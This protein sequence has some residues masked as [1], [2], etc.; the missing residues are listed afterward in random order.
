M[1][2]DKNKKFEEALPL[3][4]QAIEYLLQSMKSEHITV[5]F[6]TWEYYSHTHTHTHT[7]MHACTY[8]RT[9]T[10]THMHACTHA[11]TYTC[12]LTD[13]AHSEESIEFFRT[14]HTRYS[15][16]VE[17]LRMELKKSTIAPSVE[18]GIVQGF[19]SPLSSLCM[20]KY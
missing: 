18:K 14:K 12:T 7:R 6:N 11:H 1:E 16:R 5:S 3:Y 15:K 20:C 8:A 13:E 17:E 19:V 2:A 10:H 4:E 9:H